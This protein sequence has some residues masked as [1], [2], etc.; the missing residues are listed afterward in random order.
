MKAIALALAALAVSTAAKAENDDG[1]VKTW[2]RSARGSTPEEIKEILALD[3]VYRL[4]WMRKDAVNTLLVGGALVPVVH[5]DVTAIR[6]DFRGPTTCPSGDPRLVHH[7]GQGA[8]RY[9]DGRNVHWVGTIPS[10]SEDPC[11]PTSAAD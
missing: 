1:W 5:L 2:E 6:Y 3:G 10:G 7:S 9:A 11:A 8:A 4:E